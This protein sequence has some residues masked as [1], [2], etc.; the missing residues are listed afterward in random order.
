MAQVC[1]ITDQLSYDNA[2]SLLL[3]VIKPMRRKL[4]DYWTPLKESAYRSYKLILDKYGDMDKPMEVAE[5][6][7]KAALSK[8]TQQQEI[9]RQAEQRKA[10]LEAERIEREEKEKHALEAIDAGLPE[11]QVEAMLA[12]APVAVAPVLAPTYVKATGV[13]MRDN[14]QARVTDLKKL[15]AAVAKGTVPVTYVLANESALNA[16]AKADKETLNIPG[17]QAINNPVVSGRTK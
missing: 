11:D 5:M 2:A 4:A 1:V 10:Q 12:A 9:I 3:E 14:W 8:F 13:S 6:Q 17:V 7:V 15:C 16:R